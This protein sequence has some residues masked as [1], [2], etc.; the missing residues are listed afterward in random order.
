MKHIQ[1][2]NESEITNL[3]LDF[4]TRLE[5][6]AVMLGIS[7]HNATCMAKVP[8]Q[9]ELGPHASSKLYL[10]MLV[11]LTSVEDEDD[12]KCNRSYIR[13]ILWQSI[14]YFFC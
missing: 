6:K 10:H 14:F 1:R 11:S 5:N 12:D 2:G 7:L 3:R 13:A 9:Q 8:T 4:I